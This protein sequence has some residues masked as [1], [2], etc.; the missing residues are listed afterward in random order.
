MKKVDDAPRFLAVLYNLC[1]R[2]I[3][4]DPALAVN[5]ILTTRAIKQKALITRSITIRVVVRGEEATKEMARKGAP[6]T[7]REGAND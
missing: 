6:K 3:D 2:E 5:L 1:E 4:F 7:S